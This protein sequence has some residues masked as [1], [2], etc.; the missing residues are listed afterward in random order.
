[1]TS[2][3]QRHS[4]ALKVLFTF[5]QEIHVG[6]P[7]HALSPESQNV[8]ISLQW[9]T[10]AGALYRIHLNTAIHTLLAA[11]LSEIRARP[12]YVLS[13]R[14]DDWKTVKQEQKKKTEKQEERQGKIRLKNDSKL[15]K[16]GITR[17]VSNG[18]R[19]TGGTRHGYGKKKIKN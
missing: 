5:T 19:W 16:A 1:M 14:K 11:I 12:Y 2:Q 17:T 10:I 7:A 8:S 4:K 9:Y 13:T 15:G 6:L 3:T 18:L